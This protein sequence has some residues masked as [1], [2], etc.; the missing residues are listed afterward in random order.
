MASLALSAGVAHLLSTS[1]ALCRSRRWSSSGKA[2]L[3]V[4]PT[5]FSAHVGGDCPPARP[6]LGFGLVDDR[7]VGHGQHAF[8]RR[9][10]G[11]AA[12]M[13]QERTIPAAY[14]CLSPQNNC[15]VDIP[16]NWLPDGN[17]FYFF[18]PGGICNPSVSFQ[19]I[20]CGS[21]LCLYRQF[22][23]PGQP[24]YRMSFNRCH[25]E[26]LQIGNPV[27]R[28]HEQ[29]HFWC[30][31]IH[32]KTTQPVRLYIHHLFSRYFRTYISPQSNSLSHQMPPCHLIPPYRLRELSFQT[33]R[34]MM[35]CGHGSLPFSH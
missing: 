6:P 20:Y 16:S 28:A 34:P 32:R 31:N 14:E 7:A 10:R 5:H 33:C 12:K 15:R 18:C 3:G 22:N 25:T 27:H 30:R 4:T 35:A 23:F 8:C 1:S 17:L 21:L 9:W 26:F 29:E 19:R 2:T 11:G 13:K 24:I